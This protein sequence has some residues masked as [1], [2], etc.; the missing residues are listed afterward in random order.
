M[1]CKDNACVWPAKWYYQGAVSQPLAVHV[2]KRLHS[3]HE[4]GSV[5][6]ESGFA[7]SHP[8]ALHAVLYEHCCVQHDIVAALASPS[9]ALLFPR[10]CTAHRDAAPTRGWKMFECVSCTCIVSTFQVDAQSSGAAGCVSHFE[11]RYVD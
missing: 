10:A 4:A 6:I 7:R 9:L 1:A 5:V 3:S 8:S 2:L 11:R